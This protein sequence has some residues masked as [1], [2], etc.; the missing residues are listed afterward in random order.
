MAMAA[1]ILPPSGLPIAAI[2]L[3]GILT[4]SAYWQW[5]QR[6][7]L[8]AGQAEEL[9]AHAEALG[10]HAA[11]ALSARGEATP[12]GAVSIDSVIGRVVTLPSFGLRIV[13]AASNGRG[14]APC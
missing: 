1:R 2:L 11:R 5:Q 10:K 6:G 7:I 14:L 13:A 3:F 8:L 9:E 4:F 12:D